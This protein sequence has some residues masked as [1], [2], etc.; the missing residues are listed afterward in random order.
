MS[1]DQKTIFGT[2]V[3]VSL[4]AKESLNKKVVGVY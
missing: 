1:D 4:A 3:N 2:L